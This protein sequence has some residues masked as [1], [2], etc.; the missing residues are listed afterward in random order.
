MKNILI[1]LTFIF[2]GFTDSFSQEQ[3][4]MSYSVDCSSIAKSTGKQCQKKTR[5]NNSR[6]WNH[7]GN[8]YDYSKTKT[9]KLPIKKVGDMKYISIN[10]GGIIYDFL[11]D[12]GASTTT[13]NSKVEKKLLNSSKISKRGYQPKKYTIADGSDVILNE[14]IIS[15]LKIGGSLFRDVEVAI[16]DE[17]TSLLLGMSFLNQYNWRFQGNYLELRKK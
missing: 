3:N 15:S 5:C 16:G 14:T 1:L 2:Y 10:I 13:I 4:K 17:E 11:V 6:C 12:S 8:C 9:I 7:G